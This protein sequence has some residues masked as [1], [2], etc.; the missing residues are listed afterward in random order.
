MTPF[1]T[2]VQVNF[3]PSKFTVT[4]AGD[5][6]GSL[7]ITFEFGVGS[8]VDVRISEGAGELVGAAVKVEMTTLFAPCVGVSCAFTPQEV[9]MRSKTPAKR[10]TWHFF[11]LTTFPGFDLLSV[12]FTSYKT[13]S[14]PKRYIADKLLA[15][16][17]SLLQA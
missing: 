15:Y 9:R 16:L 13:I 10:E 6:P 5:K 7:P 11:I 3:C 12:K 2:C 1:F 4:F 14:R 8:T 17:K